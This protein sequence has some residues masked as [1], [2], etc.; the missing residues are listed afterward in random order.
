MET[1]VAFLIK[2]LEPE[3]G[4]KDTVGIIGKVDISDSSLEGLLSEVDGAFDAEDLLDKFHLRCKVSFQT[5][6]E[7]VNGIL[8]GCVYLKDNNH[9]N[10]DDIGYAL[11]SRYG[12]KG[13]VA[14]PEAVSTYIKG[15]E[16][17]DCVS[18]FDEWKGFF[19]NDL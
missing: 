5:G 14:T 11:L 9:S 7:E 1:I 6:V 17:Y 4:K 15:F 2:D 19:H 16:A 13:T 18:P 10:I 3:E 8:V 12:W